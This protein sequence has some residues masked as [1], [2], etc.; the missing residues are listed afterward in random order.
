MAHR[1]MRE[2]D[3]WTTVSVLRRYVGRSWPIVL[4][5][6]PVSARS[7]VRQTRWGGQRSEEADYIRRT[8]LAPAVYLQLKR[9]LGPEQALGAVRQIVKTIGLREMNRTLESVPSPPADP[10]RHFAAAYETALQKPPDKF[11]P[12]TIV[13]HTADRYHFRISGCI[14]HE[15]FTAVGTPELTQL[16]CEIDEAFFPVGF[17]E[18]TFHRDGDMAHTIGRGHATCEFV[19]DRTSAGASR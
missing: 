6:G 7:L 11:I 3:V 10:I 5:K 18:L 13:E 19:L 14:F 9:R 8:A 17:P 15:F 2:T 12:H 4:A 1:S 16:F